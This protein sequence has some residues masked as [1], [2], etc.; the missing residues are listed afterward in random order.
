MPDQ[1][2][3][4]K[5]ELRR[6][7]LG[8]RA[9]TGFSDNVNSAVYF[10]DGTRDGIRVV[11][12]QPTGSLQLDILP[13]SS[14]TSVMDFTTLYASQATDS[15]IDM[16]LALNSSEIRQY[17]HT[18]V[19]DDKPASNS[20][21]RLSPPNK[22]VIT[23]P[24]V[25]VKCLSP[26]GP[27]AS[28][29]VAHDRNLTN[30]CSEH[31]DSDDKGDTNADS[32]RVRS[33]NDQSASAMA[34]ATN[35]VFKS[36]PSPPSPRNLALPIILSVTAQGTGDISSHS[37]HTQLANGQTV[38]EL[39]ERLP[40]VYSANG[41][42]TLPS[43]QQ[44]QQAQVA[45]TQHQLQ[46]LQHQ[47]HPGAQVE[48]QFP[49]YQGIHFVP[50]VNLMPNYATLTAVNTLPSTRSVSDP[51]TSTHTSYFS[52]CF[53]DSS[54]AAV[55][56]V[57]S[58]INPHSEAFS[59]IHRTVCSAG[60]TGALQS[61]QK[62]FSNWITATATSDFESNGNA[63]DGLLFRD[64]HQHGN[65]NFCVNGQ[66]PVGV[67]SSGLKHVPV[68][69]CPS[70]VNGNNLGSYNGRADVLDATGVHGPV[71]HV[72]LC[73]GTAVDNV[74]HFRALPPPTCFPYGPQ[75]LELKPELKNSVTAQLSHNPAHLAG[76]PCSGVVMNRSM[77]AQQIQTG[78]IGITNV[79]G[80]MHARHG[81]L[82]AHTIQDLEEINTKALAQRIS[83][84]LKRYSIPQAVF[85]Q[86]VLCR[87]QG[88]L[89]DLLR[90]PKPWSKLKSGRETF[91]RMWKWLQEPEFQRMST[92]RLAVFDRFYDQLQAFIAKK[93]V[94]NC[95]DVP[96]KQRETFIFFDPDG[97]TA[98]KR[99]ETENVK[100][101]DSRQQ[102]KPR[103]VF[104][105]IQRRT[106]HAIFKETK[107]PSKEMQSTIAQ[108]LGLEVST[109]A[110]FFM[111]ARRRSLDKWQ[112]DCSKTSSMADSPSPDSPSSQNG[113]VN[114]RSNSVNI[115]TSKDGDIGLIGR[116]S[117]SR[118]IGT[119]T[120]GFSTSRSTAKTSDFPY[121]STLRADLGRVLRGG[122]VN[123]CGGFTSFSHPQFNCSSDVLSQSC[124][125]S[126]PYHVL[127]KSGTAVFADH[128]TQS[129]L[130]DIGEAD[131]NMQQLNHPYAGQLSGSHEV[132]QIPQ[133]HHPHHLAYQ[134]H[135]FYQTTHQQSP[136]ERQQQQMLQ[137]M[138]FV[139]R[140]D[141]YNQ[142]QESV[143]HV[144]T[145]G[146][147]VLVD[148][149]FPPTNIPKPNPA[150]AFSSA[151]AAAAA[152]AAA[153]A[154]AGLHSH[155]HQ[156]GASHL[157]LFNTNA[158]TIAGGNTMR[159]YHHHFLMRDFT[160][161]GAL[162]QNF[163]T[164]MSSGQRALTEQALELCNSLAATKAKSKTAG[165]RESK[166]SVSLDSEK[167]TTRCG[168]SRELSAFPAQDDNK[169]S[170]SEMDGLVLKNED[171]EIID[172]C[173]T[174]KSAVS[175]PAEDCD[176]SRIHN[177][178]AMCSTF[179]NNTDSDLIKDDLSSL[180]DAICG[181]V[182]SED[183]ELTDT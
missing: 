5:E 114:N 70:D 34:S 182:S 75:E 13:K 65:H 143:S 7:E 160:A 60:L 57:M 17:L 74:I 71:D 180:S 106:L 46:Q 150:F 84:E 30:H 183:T 80:P 11:T 68:N 115:C 56:D 41:E 61:E 171:S 6:N 177:T 168:H 121:Q 101:P 32:H 39:T 146:S 4:M 132:H 167:S 109:V 35:L 93:V 95:R 166:A 78:P 73:N 157:N 90:N 44:Q 23:N 170:F 108:Q 91:R 43:S 134:N 83:A 178:D 87:S 64:P 154:T 31:V 62:V 138:N 112:E 179:F 136:Q 142:G 82:P 42:P 100:T 118:V 137:H 36:M 152:A 126:N 89:S 14:E 8:S 40:T 37:F 102:K 38:S 1:V 140:P 24:V 99:R 18:S 45:T 77:A 165:E 25:G 149:G 10:V 26:T 176:S 148:S 51:F 163:L 59:A 153:V 72:Q 111:N 141:T 20:L 181:L 22:T 113:Q 159:G 129:H 116:F 27:T 123:V 48:N 175:E 2:H 94:I 49:Q 58:Y 50:D 174:G 130:S 96:L 66:R 164:N 16:S 54:V 128:I 110:N 131:V 69:N 117:P 47:Q 155:P 156:I 92:L 28:T 173:S 107:R 172:N 81:H 67:V 33:A 147:G 125:S 12:S 122:T 3:S 119:S 98:C 127:Q 104:T 144:S 63:A 53:T 19:Q 15:G 55:S 139:D 21:S 133:A 105:D 86:R 135:P 9:L 88:T 158:A 151:A 103:L 97:P 85:A 120:A 169:S 29:P 124:S 52:G 161:P 76:H 79:V 162:D 145:I